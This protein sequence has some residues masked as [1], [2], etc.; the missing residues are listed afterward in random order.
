MRRRFSISFIS[1]IFVLT[2]IH[3][4]LSGQ[5]TKYVR[6]T[7]TD[8]SLFQSPQTTENGFHCEYGRSYFSAARYTL[9]APAR[10]KWRDW[11]KSGLII[12]STVGLYAVDKDL[13]EWF[14]NQRTPITN[15]LA[16]VGNVFGE[17][18]LVIP[19]LSLFYLH[20][21]LYHN[22]R[23]QTI[24]RLGLKSFVITSVVV[25]ITKLATHRVRPDETSHP[26]Q[27]E[28]P[29]F[30]LPRCSF[31]SGH[32]AVAFSLAT[33][34]ASQYPDRGFVAPLCYSL[35]LLNSLSR[36][37]DNAH[38]ASDAFLGAALGYFIT[39]GIVRLDSQER[40]QQLHFRPA[41]RPGQFTLQV[42]MNF[43]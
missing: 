16:Q 2:F 40:N 42:S 35:A 9:T 3:E 38:W 11:S 15:S 29:G 32:A 37:N 1:F 7:P 43:K 39:Q 28:G 33:T 27:W 12:G 5:V 13:Q 17:K 26:N 30:A 10:W 23:P 21:Q 36:L 24:A 25:G 19:F 31:P 14:Q 8:T 34:I 18:L 41:I 20:S 6:I 22:E 4:P